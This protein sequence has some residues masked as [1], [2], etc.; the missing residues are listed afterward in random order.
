[1]LTTPLTR[2]EIYECITK[3]NRPML[4]ALEL[5]I[6]ELARLNSRDPD[7]QCALRCARKAVA[8]ELG[9]QANA[10]TE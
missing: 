8:L 4:T 6:E 10:P 1:M 3:R 5:C 9:F 2:R 7:V